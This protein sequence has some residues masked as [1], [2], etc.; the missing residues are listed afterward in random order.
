MPVYTNPFISGV[1]VFNADPSYYERLPKLAAG[2]ARV[3]AGDTSPANGGQYK[4]GLLGDSTSTSAG[5]GTAQT[6]DA[7]ALTG[8]RA[9]GI[10]ALLKK[11]LN[12]TYGITTRDSAFMGDQ[13][14]WSGITAPLTPSTF[15][16]SYDS[17]VAFGSNTACITN[18]N[19]RALGGLYF[20]MT[21]GGTITFTP[22]IE[23]DR[24]VAYLTASNTGTGTLTVGNAASVT[25]GSISNTHTGVQATDIANL[26]QQIA[27]IAAKANTTAIYTRSTG[28]FDVR[29]LWCY[30]SDIPGINLFQLGAYGQKLSVEAAGNGTSCPYTTAIASDLYDLLIIDMSINDMG[31]GL[32]PVATHMAALQSVV[33]AQIATG[34]EVII[35][36]PNVC[37]PA[38]VPLYL[39]YL[40]AYRSYTAANN[41]VLIDHWDEQGSY[42]IANANG[43]CFDPVSHLK[44]PGYADKMQRVAKV[45]AGV[46]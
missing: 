18:A 35:C 29:G 11:I 33:A 41:Y 36:T 4:V 39:D 21:S 40:A 17:R 31:A 5:A 10:A 7:T 28:N 16:P 9:N 32:V 3:R 43:L 37:N 19:F 42:A 34:G 38:N 44:G 23:F 12:E 14:V 13:L 15:Y 26:R 25:N 1:P 45:I 2:V 22:G 27:T 46:H 6:G 24:M 20:R 30:P 8:A